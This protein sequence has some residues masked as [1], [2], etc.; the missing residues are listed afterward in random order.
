[1]RV[2][3]VATDLRDADVLQQEVR[4]AAPKLVLDVC[5]GAAE[6][7]G[8]TE[9]S[10][11]YDVMLLD[12][13]L[14]EAEQIALIQHVRTK[15]IPL[16]I[17]LLAS[18]TTAP[19]STLLSAADECITRGPKLAER[20]APGLRMAIERYRIVATTLRDN[21]RLK[22]S[23]ARLR[24][25]IEALPA[26]V[27]LVDQ[28]GKVLAMNLAGA[29]LV[30]TAGPSDVVGRELYSL[31]DGDGA[32]RLRELVTRALTGERGR[33]EFECHG[34]DG[35]QRVLSIEALC[36]QRDET[37]GQGSVLGVLALASPETAPS[38]AGVE[39]SFGG[40]LAAMADERAAL[41]QALET[42][43]RDVERLELESTTERGRVQQLL[44]EL[45]RARA[46]A[47]EHHAHRAALDEKS[48][49]TSARLEELE[50]RSRDEQAAME[51]VVSR[52][53]TLNDEAASL[54]Q[55][56]QRLAHESDALKQELL[57]QRR[58]RLE[59]EERVAAADVERERLTAVLAT[60]QAASETRIGQLDDE[61][62]SL[63]SG[64]GQMT[65]RERALA[66]EL[67]ATKFEASR[68]KDDLAREGDSRTRLESELEQ[69]RVELRAALGGREADQATTSAQLAEAQATAQ[70]AAD[71]AQQTEQALRGELEAAQQREQGLRSELD[72][73]QQREQ[74]VR[75]DL[76]AATQRE[77]AAHGDLESQAQARQQL[78]F[79]L[80]Q[81]GTRVIELEHQLADASNRESAAQQELA[82]AV[83]A[84]HDLEA[85]AS[86][87]AARVQQLE[88]A[89][90]EQGSQLE[91]L[92]GELAASGFEA[93]QLRDDL[94]RESETRARLESELEARAFD[95]G[96]VRASADADRDVFQARISELENETA[97]AR[98]REDE[99]AS[100]LVRL[101]ELEVSTTEM[102]ARRQAAVA[103]VAEL[104]ER[105][106]DEQAALSAAAQR[107]A[108][109]SQ[110]LLSARDEASRL[111]G[112][113]A[114]VAEELTRERDRRQTIE[115]ELTVRS[116]E[117]ARV[118]ADIEGQL[119]AHEADVAALR[120][121]AETQAQALREAR[122][123]AARL[124]SDGR[125]H[126]TRLDSELEAARAQ[127]EQASDREAAM[128]GELQNLQQERD[129]RGRQA[130]EL[131]AVLARERD[132]RI[133]L[134]SRLQVL[135]RDSADAGARSDSRL[136]DM[137]R[138]HQEVVARLQKLLEQAAAREFQAAAL[139]TPRAGDRVR[140]RPAEKIGQ[141]AAAMANDLNA[142]IADVAE[143]ARRLLTE[144]PDGTTSRARAEQTLQ[145]ATRAGQLVRH[146]LRLSERESRMIPR[147]EV[148]AL[149]RS[150]ETLLRQL[151]GADIDLRFELAAGLAHVECDAEEVVQVLSTFVVTLRGSLPLGGVIRVSTQE[152]G[153]TDG[154]RRGDSA[155]MLSVAAEGYGMVPVPT[156][157]CEEVVTRIG[158]V[159][160]S[161]ADQNQT[162]TSLQAS[163]PTEARATNEANPG[164]SQTA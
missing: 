34:P 20:L 27:V 12:A 86:Q 31:A 38:D 131:E 104:E 91:A 124:E 18:Q 32:Q 2:L 149:V 14:A 137:Q 64:I 120:S 24:L 79:Q 156:A 51:A 13:S 54:R 17:A 146:L 26:G 58:A 10:L 9:R 151:A 93:T 111:S 158:G 109:L 92:A 62:R 19:S 94:T 67:D 68:L 153:R 37:Q 5:A 11:G 73:A 134:Q 25:I 160:S 52:A 75:A 97:S 132:E 95:L 110:E 139:A 164:W 7:R 103:R 56:R 72:A 60:A 76:D 65:T 87:A 47:A 148:S 135:E 82:S 89:A 15:Q 6:A 1:M 116:A 16:P 140:R 118:R 3:Y 143:D 141:L 59:L 69:A 78:E 163:L 150:N 125:A 161:S 105:R 99:Q 70:A 50:A 142:T 136:A 106:R 61:L 39:F 152:R 4:R 126:A 42:M 147:V 115:D 88:A 123:S 112:E 157:G 96:S 55:E 162:V 127:L 117:L 48:R 33:T 74:A 41:D 44:A 98:A 121:E 40:D 108:E 145:T 71:A 66:A 22:R 107:E 84:R 133:D 138:D 8:R 77:Q 100:R 21:E 53:G 35:A 63:K 81:S 28:A 101:A 57:E 159:F 119:A 154:R 113:R 49:H 43:R 83:A 29:S 85:Q 23:E 122:E 102:E 46:T 144:L 36:I 80:T 90:A 128:A 30:G 45:E 130:F 129:A 114:G 155:L